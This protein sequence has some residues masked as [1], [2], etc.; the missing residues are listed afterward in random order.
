MGNHDGVISAAEW[1][2]ANRDPTAFEVVDANHSG[3]ITRSE[4][5]DPPITTP[6]DPGAT[7]TATPSEAP[8][9]G[10]GHSDAKRSAATPGDPGATS[11]SEAPLQGYY[12]KQ[13]G[14]RQPKVDKP[15]RARRARLR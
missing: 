6:G 1:N 8:L 11:T 13:F 3:Q 5:Y 12:E 15:E 9:H 7:S 2:A 14:Q 10:N 4:Y